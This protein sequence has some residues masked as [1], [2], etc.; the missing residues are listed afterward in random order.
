MT[1]ADFCGGAK[2]IG[3]MQS[4]V[5][6]SGAAV[7]RLAGSMRPAVAGPIQG[8]RFSGAILDHRAVVEVWPACVAEL[9]PAPRSP[10][11]PRPRYLS[12]GR[13]DHRACARTANLTL[14]Y[15]LGAVR[16]C[17]RRGC[18]ARADRVGKPY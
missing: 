11:L 16:V 15:A 17:V 13:L 8:E 12:R 18:W 10:R 7:V 3:S 9:P 5:A 6:L 2:A 1:G 14:R 4:G